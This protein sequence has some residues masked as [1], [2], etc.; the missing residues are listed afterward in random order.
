MH[1]RLLVSGLVVGEEIRVLVERLPDPGDVAMAED[2]E[3][4][5]EK[6][7]LYAVALHVL[8]GEKADETLGG[9]DS[10]HWS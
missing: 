10:G 4:P 1:H 6:A 5:L 8:R 9:R 3:A 7:L 2:A